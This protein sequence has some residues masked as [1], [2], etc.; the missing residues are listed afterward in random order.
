MNEEMSA[1]VSR[2]MDAIREH[3]GTVELE[4][5]I[6][7]IRSQAFDYTKWQKEHY[8]HMTPEEIKN[9]LEQYSKNHDFHGKKAVVL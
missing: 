5:F 6:Y 2:C 8:D 7:Y 3:V 4:V 1:T 9:L